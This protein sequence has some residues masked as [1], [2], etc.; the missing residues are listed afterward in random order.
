MTHLWYNIF[1]INLKINESETNKLLKNKK[2]L[3]H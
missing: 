1:K 3:M 2:I